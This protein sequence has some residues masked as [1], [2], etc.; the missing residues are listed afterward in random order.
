[1]V[2]YTDLAVGTGNLHNNSKAVT[3]ALSPKNTD[4]I[5]LLRTLEGRPVEKEC[6]KAL[7]KQADLAINALVVDE[8][9]EEAAR[10]V[11]VMIVAI[12]VAGEG[13]EKRA[14]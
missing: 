1:M 7:Q 2:L 14:A 5:N 6:A 8:N 9:V 11:R 10:R 12:Y 3:L 13:K 4:K